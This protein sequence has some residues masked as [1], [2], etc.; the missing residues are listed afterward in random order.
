[1]NLNIKQ[2]NIEEPKDLVVLALIF[3]FCALGIYGMFKLLC[4]SCG[5][6]RK[7]HKDIKK[8]S[9]ILAT[10]RKTRKAA[11]IAEKER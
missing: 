1:M 8:I 6:Y 7:K 5:T 9:K 4:S 11:K 10:K 2:I 3:T